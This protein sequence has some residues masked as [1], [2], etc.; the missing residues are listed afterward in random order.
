MCTLCSKAFS[1][2]G[3]LKKHKCAP[4]ENY[5]NT[6]KVQILSHKSI[7]LIVIQESILVIG[8]PCI[9]HSLVINLYKLFPCKRCPKTFS[10]YTLKIHLWTHTGEKPYNCNKYPK[11]FLQIA[12]F[13]RHLRS[14]SS[15]KSC[16]NYCAKDFTRDI[17]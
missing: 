4:G 7:I 5:I 14:H 3:N 17:F 2:D 8:Q 16:C 15:K 9:I 1:M 11:V 13:N 12:H 6:T 10:K